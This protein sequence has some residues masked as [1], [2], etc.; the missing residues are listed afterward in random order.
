[1]LSRIASQ[2]RRFGGWAVATLIWLSGCAPAPALYAE[3]P[4]HL[5]PATN[6][7]VVQGDTIVVNGRHLRLASIVTPQPAPNAK[8]V[9][10]AVAARQ[11]HLRLVAL[12]Q[13]VQAVAI[14]PTGKV[15]GYGRTE[16]NVLFDGHDPTSTLIEEGLAL[17][18]APVRTDWCSP[19]S[20]ARP[21][22]MRIAVLSMTPR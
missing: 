19:I 20:N 14:E 9:A 7:T 1:M 18:A 15:D 10:E 8:C 3:L 5:S 4:A 22:A 11:A 12:S 21:E 13:G 17:P 2:L 16:A 6:I